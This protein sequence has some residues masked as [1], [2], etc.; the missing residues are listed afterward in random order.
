MPFNTFPTL[1]ASAT[2]K[3]P[4]ETWS[5]P[6]IMTV[7]DDQQSVEVINTGSGGFWENLQVV[8]QAPEAEAD[9]IFAFLVAQRLR[10]IPFNFA[11][12]K[13]GT[14]LVRYF[15]NKLP[16][17]RVLSGTPDLVEFDLPLRAL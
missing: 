1:S 16:Y 10:G 8:I 3:Y 14:I 17:K 7:F 15:S 6:D 12:R 5:D 13:R 9:A 11:H 2:I 4:E